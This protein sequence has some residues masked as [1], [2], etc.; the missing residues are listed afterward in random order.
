[1]GEAWN[2]RQDTSDDKSTLELYVAGDNLNSRR[3]VANLD[4]VVRRLDVKTKVLIVDVLK[5]PK[6][7]FTRRIFV[8]P[9]LIYTVGGRQNLVVGDLSDVNGV[10]EKLRT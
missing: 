2:D 10:L 9:S 4:E 1:M 7:A 5:E 6:T 8:T 3:A